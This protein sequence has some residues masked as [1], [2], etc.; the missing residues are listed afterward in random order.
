MLITHATIATLGTKPQLI[1]DGAILVRGHLIE[2]IGD[3]QTLATQYPEEERLDAEGQLAMPAAL[4]G[5]LCCQC[6]CVA[7]GFNEVA[8]D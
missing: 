6:L 2:A 7:D 3:T 5:V 1:E 4:C 8:A